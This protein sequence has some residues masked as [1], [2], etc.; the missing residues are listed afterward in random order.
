MNLSNVTG[1][2]SYV[3]FFDAFNMFKFIFGNISDNFFTLVNH[4]NLLI[5][6]CVLLLLFFFINIS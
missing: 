4:S 2:I 1:F 3:S 6:Y 5:S